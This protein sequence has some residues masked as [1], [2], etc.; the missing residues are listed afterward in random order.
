MASGVVVSPVAIG[1]PF[2]NATNGFTA[3]NVQAAIEE[4]RNSPAVNFISTSAADTLT[5]STDTLLAGM[6]YTNSSGA[7]IKVLAEFNGDVNIGATGGVLSISFYLNGVQVTDTLRK[8]AGDQGAL[9]GSTRVTSSTN[10]KV[11]IPNGQILQIRW[12]ASAGTI[13][14]ASRSLCLTKCGD[15]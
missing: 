14:A 1:I 15:F 5:S 11:T 2:N 7:S 6:T 3:I 9:A 4:A 8:Q 13:T 12:S 10:C